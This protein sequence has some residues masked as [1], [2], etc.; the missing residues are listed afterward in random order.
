MA[1][2]KIFLLILV[3]AV[4]Y[5]CSMYGTMYGN[6]GFVKGAGWSG[7][8]T[9]GVSISQYTFSPSPLSFTASYG[10]TVTWTNN[11]N[12]THN[13]T[14]DTSTWVA[15]TLSPGMTFS[16]TFPNVMATYSYHCTIHNMAGS[17]VAN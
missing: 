14:S 15:K 9:A 6:N 4:M 8:T 13:V 2:R 16:Y 11:D 17:V 5:G 1:A 3:M 10:V 7:G 12:V